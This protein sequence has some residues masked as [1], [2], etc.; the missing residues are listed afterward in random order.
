MEMKQYTERTWQSAFTREQDGRRLMTVIYSGHAT[1][2]EAEICACRQ[3]GRYDNVVSIDVTPIDHV[4]DYEDC[5]ED[6]YNSYMW[7]LDG[8]FAARPGQEVTSE[9]YQYMMDCLPPFRLPKT[10]QTTGYSAGFLVGEPYD[11]DQ[12]GRLRY[13][14]FAKSG[15]HYFFL[16]Y[17]PREAA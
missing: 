8:S 12:D 9:I 7:H 16:G 11:S 5:G 17:L 3:S 4:Y 10:E 15:E 2:K 14:A 6:V 13:P 1:R